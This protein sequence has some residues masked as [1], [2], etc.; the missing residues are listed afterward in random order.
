MHKTNM[1][2]E[3]KIKIKSSAGQNAA[4]QRM[5]RGRAGFTL[6]ELLVVIA[7]IAILAAMLLPAL[8][9]AKARALTAEC[10]N[11]MKQ[12]QICYQIYAS[13]NNEQLPLNFVNNPPGNW[14]ANAG[15]AQVATSDLPIR[16]GVLFLYNNQPKIY[17]C[18]AN[19]Q[20]ILD[21]TPGDLNFNQMV[22]QTRTCSIEYSLG[23]NSASSP[24]GPWTCTRGGTPVVWNT[25]SKL[26]SVKRTSSKIV[27]VDEAQSTL[28]DGEFATYPLI[29]DAPVNI[30]WNIPTTRH[31]NGSTWSFADGHTE[32]W[33]YRGAA[34]L[35]NQSNPSNPGNGGD[36]AGDSP[37]GSTPDLA[38]VEA[39]G[40]EYP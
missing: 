20:M 36:I 30:W 14:I 25:Y 5:A 33:K 12:L 31:S 1:I 32:Y 19:T 40:P 24:T 38:K 29:P 15:L 28:N 16:Q 9:K 2:A 34:V 26:T 13:D 4:P 6:I 23:G 10:L 7:I 17:A 22:P 39:S 27:F 37:W 18:P 35:N 3:L 21:S 11:N 8:S